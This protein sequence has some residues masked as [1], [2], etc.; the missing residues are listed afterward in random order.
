MCEWRKRIWV[1]VTVALA[2]ATLGGDALFSQGQPAKGRRIVLLDGREVVEGEVIIRYRAEA[3]RFGRQRAELQADSDGSEVIGP[4]GARRMR[5]RDLTTREMLETLRANPDVE[6]VEPNYIIRANAA[7]NDPSMGSLWGL[8]NTGQVVDGQT[9]VAG[10]DISATAA[11]DV[12]TGSRANIVAILDTGIDWSHPDLAANVFSAPRQ[13]SVTLGSTTLTCVAGTH[14]FNALNTSCSPFDDNGHGTHVAGIIGAVGNNSVGVTGVNWTANLMALKILDA[15]GTGT[16]ADAIKAIDWVIKA[17]AALGVDG[18]VRVLNASWGGPTFSQALNDAIEMANNADMLFV[19]SA[20]S[21]S[22]N[23]DSLPHYPASS[24]SSNVIS[25]TALDNTGALAASSNYGATSVDIGAPGGLSTLSTLPGNTYG[26]QSGTSMAAPYVA[27]AAALVLSRCSLSTA[28]LKSTILSRSRPDT[29]L[30]G[31]TATGG[32]LDL[33]GALA[34]CL[35]PSLKV[36]GTSDPISVSPSSTL[37][38]TVANGPGNQYDWITIVPVGSADTAYTGIWF[39][40]GSSSPPSSGR[41]SATFTIPAPSTEGTYEVRFLANGRYQRLATS[42]AIT[43]GAGA[44][45]PPPPP[46]SGMLTVNGSTGALSVA[47]GSPLTITITNGPGN[48]YDWVTIVPVGSPDTAYTGIW[49]LSGTSTPPSS[50]KT[51]AT[52][53]IPAPSTAGDYEVRFLANGKYQRLATS[54]VITVGAGSPPPPPPPPS[55]MLTVN[56]STGALS[57]AAGSSL[58]ITITNGPGNVY[59]WVTI[60]PVGS[61]DTAY[62]G[63]WFLSGTS[64]PP[65]SGRTNATFA[66][67]APSTAGQY[68]VRFLANG[69]YQRLATSGVITVGAGSPPPPPPPPSGM[70]TVNGSTGALSV[71]AGSSLT[72]T[73]TNGPGNVYDWVTIVPVGS[74]DTAYT[75]IWFLS[76]TSTPPS[77]GKTNATFPIPAPSTAGEYE[78]RFLANG[79]Y[80]RLATSGVITVGAGSPPPPP[81]ASGMLTVNGSTDAVAASSGSSLTIRI[82]NGPG[83]QYDWVTIVPVGSADTA[84]TGI[85]FLSGTSTPPATGLTNAT[86]AIPTP[87]APGNYEVRFLANGRYQRLATS[88]V[89]TVN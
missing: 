8:F 75:G 43:V 67:P 32:R 7:A 38:I 73:I 26:H 5:S 21:A 17:K 59:D 78:V 68:E 27:G 12:T 2:V 33:E 63:I 4:L 70:L 52:F 58:T 53:A 40:N 25:V 65:P 41:T 44:P 49:F 36:N 19:A 50:G 77:S 71:A 56:G 15:A 42:A 74:A 55:G 47:T 30:T 60:V 62:T 64:T 34:G 46:P 22:S 80:Q 82:T 79:K 10:A 37:T 57:V 24:T 20:G 35:P 45:P 6:L 48:V 13:F 85:W 86:F 31:K 89:I 14:G 61:P 1:S 28:A 72:I 69:K 3:G 11:W 23:N 16:T 83:N 51:N 76:G 18:N 54:G 88:G 87:T 66:I 39:L 9:G 81:P 84:Y 29:R